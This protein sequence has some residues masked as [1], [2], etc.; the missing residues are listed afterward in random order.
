MTGTPGRGVEHVV[1][2]HAVLAREVVAV[3]VG[4]AAEELGDGGG[5]VDQSTAAWD[6]TVVAHALARDHERCPRLH[7]PE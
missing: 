6:D 7:D 1:A 4:R 3:G 2:H 5:D